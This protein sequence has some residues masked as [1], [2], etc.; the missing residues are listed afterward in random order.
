MFS[1]RFEKSFRTFYPRVRSFTEKIIELDICE[2]KKK[3]QYC[4]PNMIGNLFGLL[5]HIRKSKKVQGQKK[6]DM[7]FN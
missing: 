7:I 4:R 2:E 6:N 1:R 5:C 3:R